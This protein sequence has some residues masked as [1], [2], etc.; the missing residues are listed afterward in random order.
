MARVRLG[1]AGWVFDEWRGEFYPAGL[2]QKEELAYASRHLGAIEINSTFYSHQKAQ[3]FLN[4]AAETP[5]D[6]MFTVKGH[7]LITH[8]K[9]LKDVELP[10][11]NFFASGVLALGKRLGAFCWQLPPNLKYDKARLE[12]FLA[13]LPKDRDALLALAGKHQGLK[14][15]PYLDAS[16]I[17]RVRHAIEVRH[18]S[19]ANPQFIELMRA[20]NVA[21][22]T[23]DTAEWPTTD[24]TAD[25]VYC[26]LQGAPGKEQYEPA[27]IDSRAGWLEA[28]SKGE[29]AADAPIVTPAAKAGPRDVFAFFVSTDKKHAPRNAMMVMQ[30]LGLAAPQ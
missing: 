28:W 11:A 26:R 29:I 23:A 7:Q 5:D 30:K 20:H 4:W 13:L 9:R 16:E 21:L 18:E 19:F 27:E 3:S 12:T 14:N 17:D 22:V 1:I 25:F 15:E 2:K 6:F 8:I 10:L 24:V